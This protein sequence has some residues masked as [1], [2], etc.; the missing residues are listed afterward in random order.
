MNFASRFA[1]LRFP[2]MVLV[3]FIHADNRDIWVNGTIGVLRPEGDFALWLR[4]FLSQGVARVAVPLFFAISGYLFFLGMEGSFVEFVRKW[5][6]RARTLLMPFV[7]WSI[8]VFVIVCAVRQQWPYTHG[9]EATLNKLF[10]LTKPMYL[11]H[12]WFLRDLILMILLAPVWWFLGQD[13]R[14]KVQVSHAKV[15]ACHAKVQACH[16]KVQACHARHGHHRELPNGAVLPVPGMTKTTELLQKIEMFF[17]RLPWFLRKNLAWVFLAIFAGVHLFYPI[18]FPFPSSVGVLYFFL[19]CV[20]AMRNWSG[21]TLDYHGKKWIVAYGV[22]ALV[23]SFDSGNPWSRYVHEASLFVG[24]GAFLAFAKMIQTRWGKVSR[25]LEILAPASFFLYA[26]HEPL[27][28]YTRHGLNLL[29]PGGIDRGA[30]LLYLLPP[31]FA[32]VFCT[33]LYFLAIRRVPIL[34]TL[35]AG[36]R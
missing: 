19:G 30:Y 14:I 10:G 1:V 9:L 4:Y 18:Q 22:I 25:V 16:A 6:N 27:L 15:Q 20:L 26:G 33:S 7:A 8:F 2:L 17:M 11:F 13:M 36:G 3:A 21:L 34:K 35:F 12:F 5:R 24:C 28:H 31:L 23:D 32:V 29:L